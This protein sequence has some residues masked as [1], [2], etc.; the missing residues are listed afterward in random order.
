MRNALITASLLIALSVPAPTEAFSLKA[1]F[2]KAAHAGK[3]VAKKAGQVGLY[4]A[5]G[6]AVIVFCSQGACN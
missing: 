2:V 3:A 6:V 1:P 4:I 5:A